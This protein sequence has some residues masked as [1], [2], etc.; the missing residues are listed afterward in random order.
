MISAKEELLNGHFPSQGD[1]LQRDLKVTSSGGS[2]KCRSTCARWGS[3]P[4]HAMNEKQSLERFYLNGENRIWSR[5][6]I[7]IEHGKSSRQ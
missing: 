7:T 2:R 6:S 4:S 3:D 5:D 1:P